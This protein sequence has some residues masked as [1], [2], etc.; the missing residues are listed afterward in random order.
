MKSLVQVCFAAAALTVCAASAED[1]RN[2]STES[3]VGTPLVGYVFD[4]ID[5]GI[6][7]VWGVAGASVVGDP[8]DIGLPVSS[9]AVSPKQDFAVLVS[10]DDAG[11][12]VLSLQSGTFQVQP[13]AQ[14]A[15]PPNQITFSPSG[16]SVGLY[17]QDSATVQ[18]FTHMPEG[19]AL[20][21]EIHTFSLNGSLHSL[22]VS[23]DGD[24]TLILMRDQDISTVW[25]S[26]SGSDPFQLTQ[27][28]QSTAAVEFRGHSHDVVA[29]TTDGMIGIFRDIDPGSGYQTLRPP[30]D[31]IADPVAV[32]FSA[33]GS[34]VYLTTK[35]GTVASIDSQTGSAAVI[36]CNCAPS[37][38]F[39]LQ[40]GTLL[41]LND[42]S[43]G[44]LMLLDASR[45][46][47]HVWFVPSVI[48]R[49][50]S[51]GVAQ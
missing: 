34:R 35:R 18:I 28:P 48:T 41:R 12:R 22:A 14:F 8:L 47:L 26:V 17:R 19:P 2:S 45:P 30:D 37:G 33:D 21:H 44:P 29:A 7:P 15:N 4:R 46:E 42:L 25:L 6:R 3:Q 23:D 9:A 11:V 39:P 31:R 32:R 16:A 50:S 40:P 49:K 51:D 5:K 36:S 1:S 24:L 38:L 13:L 27:A 43:N 20:S 10:S